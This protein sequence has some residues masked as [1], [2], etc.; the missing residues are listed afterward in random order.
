MSK[1]TKLDCQLENSAQSDKQRFENHQSLDQDGEKSQTNNIR[2]L[3]SSMEK[4]QESKQTF[5][6]KLG[7]K[8]DLSDVDLVNLRYVDLSV[9]GEWTVGAKLE[10]VVLAD[11]T[12]P[13][14]GRSSFIL[15]HTTFYDIFK[16]ITVNDFSIR[17]VGFNNQLILIVIS[18]KLKKY[19]E[20][21]D[22]KIE[23][24]DKR[25]HF[26]GMWVDKSNSFSK[27]YVYKD[28]VYIRKGVKDGK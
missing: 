28:G 20:I 2:T 7:F 19:A 23:A 8:K 5:L 9:D 26:G 14:I 24:P 11:D 4:T 27:I 6:E 18:R 21:K 3:E 25:I 16:Y 10:V 15:C 22:L 12:L 1:K 17:A 13:F